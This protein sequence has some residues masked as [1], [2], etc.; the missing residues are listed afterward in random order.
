MKPLYEYIFKYKVLNISIKSSDV[1][2]Y[3]DA[4]KLLNILAPNIEIHESISVKYI[5]YL[6]LKYIISLNINI[7]EKSITVG[8]QKIIK[9]SFYVKIKYNNNVICIDIFINDNLSLHYEIKK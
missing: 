3:I 8:L 5:A 2:N 9:K 7:D 1:E 4:E 6:V